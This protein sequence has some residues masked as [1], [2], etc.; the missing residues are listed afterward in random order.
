VSRERW[1]HYR[2]FLPRKQDPV[3]ELDRDVINAGIEDALR[4][5]SE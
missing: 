1:V 2:K 5:S 3:G 4:A